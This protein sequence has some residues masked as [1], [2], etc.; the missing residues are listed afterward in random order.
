M[1]SSLYIHLPF[2]TRKCGY[3][4]F[5]VLPDKA[6]LKDQLLAGLALEWQLAKEQFEDQ[7][8][9]SVYFG[10]GTPALFGPDR[11]AEVISWIQKSPAFCGDEIEIT[12][13]AN[14][15]EASEG[16]IAAYAEAGVNRL[17]IGVQSFDDGLLK[18]LTRR[19]SAQKASDTVM[20]AAKAGIQNISIDLMYEVPGQTMAM[21]EETLQIATDLPITHLSL[22]NLTIEPETPFHRRRHALQ[23]IVPPEEVS[24]AMYERARS[25]LSDAGLLQYEISAFARDNKRSIHNSGYWLGRP[26][27]GLG[28]SAFSYWLGS[29]FR[30]CAHLNKYCEALNEGQSPVDFHETLSTQASRREHLI[31]QLRLCQ[32]VN[33][34]HFQQQFGPL[35]NETLMIIRQLQSQGWLIQSDGRWLLTQEGQLFYD[36][37]AS[38]LI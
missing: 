6:E 30:N 11:I 1:E 20:A 36:A 31:L 21:W 5:Y 37:V 8:L 10:G 13:E 38:E 35:E 24:R 2:C 29:R 7:K 27:L 26:F 22:Y 14:P 16:L 19:H 3:C 25:R 17:S 9:V 15:E 18:Q 28:P 23:L 34:A 12:L 33:L 4:H 32:G